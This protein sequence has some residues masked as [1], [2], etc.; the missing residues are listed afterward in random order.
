M[1]YRLL[2]TRGRRGINATVHV[3]TDLLGAVAA[4][5]GHFEDTG[6][7]VAVCEAPLDGV[8]SHVA[9]VPSVQEQRRLERESKKAPV[10][11]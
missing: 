10:S 11:A 3:H 4:A 7:P 1:R 5:E 9:T 8:V 2:P 6:V